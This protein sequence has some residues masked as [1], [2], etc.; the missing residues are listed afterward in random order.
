[1]HITVRR[2]FMQV[3]LTS[4]CGYKSN[5]TASNV[6]TGLKHSQSLVQVQ[7]EQIMPVGSSV[8]E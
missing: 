1:M 8:N 4:D 5:F 7:T 3:S 2:L 6:Q